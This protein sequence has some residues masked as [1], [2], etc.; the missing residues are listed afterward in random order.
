MNSFAVSNC[1]YDGTSGDPNPLCILTG[2][3]NGMNVY[4]QPFFRYLMAAS[5]ADQMQEALTS[6]MF[7]FY[8]GYR[9]TLPWPNPIPFPSFPASNAV[10]VHSEGIYPVAPT[11]V[12]E[13]LIGSWSA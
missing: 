13:A 2:T 1:T 4:P 8:C 9:A 3:V 5:A 12:S 6:L 7:N 10:A 11:V